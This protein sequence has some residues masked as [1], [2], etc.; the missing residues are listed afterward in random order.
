MVMEINCDKRHIL[1]LPLLI[2]CVGVQV[3]Y[4]S[5]FSPEIKDLLKNLLQTDLTKRF[6]NL[7]NGVIDIKQHKWF[8]GT[9]WIALYQRKVFTNA[10]FIQFTVFFPSCMLIQVYN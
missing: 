5:H 2:I 4:P 3:R 6:G 7:K 8:L 9:D 1:Y 10:S